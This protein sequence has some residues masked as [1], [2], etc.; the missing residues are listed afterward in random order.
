MNGLGLHKLSSNI[1]ITLARQLA[2]G[3][4]QLLIIVIIARVYGPEVNG[5][6]ALALLLPSMLA[7]FLNLGIGPANVY[8]L[9]SMQFSP[10]HVLAFNIKIAII[11]SVLGMAAGG[12]IIY[13]KAD[14]FFPGVQHMMLWLALLSFP[15]SLMQSFISSIFQ[16]LQKFREFNTILLLQPITTLGIITT[17]VMF[18]SFNLYYL[19]VAHLVG[20]LVTLQFSSMLLRKYLSEDVE[21]D[22]IKSYSKKAIN[23]GYKAH[24]SNMMT[25]INYKADIFLVNFFL[26]PFSAGIYVIS[27][28]LGEK[29]WM[30][31]QAISTVLLPKLSE[32]SGDEHKRLQITPVITRLTLYL[33]AF[34][35]IIF[36]FLAY[37]LIRL[38]FGVE[39][40]DA[41]IPLLILLP[42]IILFSAFRIIANDLAARGM[43]ELNL[44]ISIVVVV[45]NILGNILMIPSYGLLG[46]AMATTLAYTF[47]FVLGLLIY[48]HI[49]MVSIA[50]LVVIRNSDVKI[51][52]GLVNKIVGKE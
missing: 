8:Y 35:G 48:R 18:E 45:S 51:I 34:L 40:L 15:A 10:R 37:P 16:G 23:Y 21:E 30:L 17:L 49:T 28:Q 22:S 13:Y 31:S 4:L 32:L 43:P 38:I 39:Y 14:D 25:F 36:V 47:S 29:L 7:T 41:Y 9:G 11:L 26:N 6:Y 12:V 5:A 3:L 2:S 52:F 27:V 20:V 33:T 42:G 24:L 50:N 44:Y 1:V 46:A 19:I